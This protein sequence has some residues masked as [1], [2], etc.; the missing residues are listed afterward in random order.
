MLEAT[1]LQSGDLIDH[2]ATTMLPPGTVVALG[3]L[4]GVTTRAAQPGEV[5]GLALTGIYDVPA[6]IAGP[7]P[8]GTRVYWHPILRTATLDADGGAHPYLGISV[9]AHEEP[10]AITRLRVRLNH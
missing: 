2:R 4:V 7:L 10:T 6:Q 1:F 3:E 9:E 5:I 8:V